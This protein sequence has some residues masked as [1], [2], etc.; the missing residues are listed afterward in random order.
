MGRIFLLRHAQPQFSGTEYIA[1]G[2]LTNPTLS[3]YGSIV[4]DDLNKCFAAF[5][6]IAVYSSPM[7]RCQQTAQAIAQPDKNVVILPDVIEMDLGEWDGMSFDEIR[8]RW[9]EHYEKRGADPSIPPPGGEC[10][11]AAADRMEKA[12]L[13]ITDEIAVVVSHAGANRALLC[14]LL[15]LPMSENRSIPQSYGAINVIDTTGGK[16]ELMSCGKNWD[17]LPDER[18]IREILSRCETPENVRN[19][20]RAVAAVADEMSARLAQKGSCINR[21]MLHVAATL[22][23]MCRTMPHHPLSAAEI[24]A[25]MGYLHLA[26]IV[27]AHHDC[28]EDELDEK[29]LLFLADKLVCGEKKVSIAERFDESMKKCRDG[30][31]RQANI[32]RRRTAEKIW[33]MYTDIVL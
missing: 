18:E 22:H 7:L 25:G 15:G 3:E 24:L 14:R 5:P 16:L 6:N 21:E 4:A 17:S 32:R 28:A 27:A 31:A 20:C 26:A 12:L 33:K 9:P 30:Q 1:L 2:R 29:S 10:F 19:H 23:D 11:P 8:R 13:S